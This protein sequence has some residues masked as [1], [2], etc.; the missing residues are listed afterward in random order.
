M[1]DPISAGM[2]AAANLLNTEPVNNLL[3]PG[4]KEVGLLLG[5]LAGAFR[6]CVEGEPR[7]AFSEVG[8]PASE[9][10]PNSG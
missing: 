6:L 7:N 8:T 4:T 5:S 9:S 10:T 2:N 3:S 1:D